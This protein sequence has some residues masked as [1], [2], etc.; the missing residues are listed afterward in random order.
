ME[1]KIATTQVPINRLIAKRWSSRAYHPEKP[2]TADQRLALFEAARWAPSCYGDQPWYL[3]AL[4]KFENQAS[5]ELALDC[6]YEG[7]RIWAKDAPLILVVT[8][9]ATLS[10]NEEPN[11][12]AEYD[13]GAAMENLVLQATDMGLMSRQIGGF[14]PKKTRSSFEIPEKFKIMSF[15][16]I[17]HPDSPEKLIEDHTQA[18]QAERRRNELEQHFFVSQWGESVKVED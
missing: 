2:V 6:L 3:L 16:A 15:I 4:D 12:W 18:E 10:L 11:D 13:T 7:N 5:W 17:G 14:I 8:A 1:H 9:K